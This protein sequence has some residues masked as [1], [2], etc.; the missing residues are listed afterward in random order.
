MQ[1]VF[2]FKI[3][4]GCLPALGSYSKFSNNTLKDVLVTSV[5]S[6]STSLFMG[7]LVFSLVGFLAHVMESDITDVI[8]SGPALVF[9]TFPN[10][11]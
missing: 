4:L 11:V 1:V 7:V 8:T 6:A 5:L 3:G 10:L 2:N 9:V